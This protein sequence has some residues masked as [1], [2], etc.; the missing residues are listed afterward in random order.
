M[1]K[2]LSEASAVEWAK[3]LDNARQAIANADPNLAVLEDELIK[4]RLRRYDVQP[5]GFMETE[6]PEGY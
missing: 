6:K 2:G 5:L 3:E 4:K 1:K